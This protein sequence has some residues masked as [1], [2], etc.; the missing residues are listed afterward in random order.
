MFVMLAFCSDR[1]IDQSGIKRAHQAGW[2][3]ILLPLFDEF[4]LLTI[5]L[6][7][8]SIWPGMMN[9]LNDL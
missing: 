8:P 5:C 6:P 2:V 4:C 7:C 1:Y 3:A 9:H